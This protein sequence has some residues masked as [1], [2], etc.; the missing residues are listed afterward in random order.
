MIMKF[1]LD[2]FNVRG[3]TSEIKKEQLCADIKSYHL[4]LVC[5]QETEIV[6]GTNRTINKSIFD[7]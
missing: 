4:D 3:L 2:I 1:N 6:N 7:P 5:S